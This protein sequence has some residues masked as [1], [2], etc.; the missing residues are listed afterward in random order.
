MIAAFS[1]RELGHVLAALRLYQRLIGHSADPDDIATDA[2]RHDPMSLDEIDGLCERLNLFRTVGDATRGLPSM[3]VL[4]DGETWTA[5]DDVELVFLPADAD[6]DVMGMYDNGEDADHIVPEV[7]FT[8]PTGVFD[9]ERLVRGL[10]MEVLEAYRL[11]AG[12]EPEG[13]A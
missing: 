1:A 12:R 10:P 9:L 4:N 13:P 5:L 11:K 2:G 8:P 6:H 3:V 7:R